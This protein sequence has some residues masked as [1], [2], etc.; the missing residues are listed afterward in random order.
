MCVL[1]YSSTICSKDCLCS[2]VLPLLLCQRSVD[3]ICVGLYLSSL[4][5]H[6]SVL[7]VP[8]CHSLLYLSLLFCITI[9]F[10]INSNSLTLLCFFS[11]ELAVL[12][13]LHLHINF[14]TSC[15]YPQSGTPLRY[16]CL[17]NPMDGGA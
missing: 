17:E 2:I 3:S 9:C 12:H 13:L 11:I 5:F 8:H 1:N 4:V 6:W 14:R 10:Q 16:S 7:S 15:C